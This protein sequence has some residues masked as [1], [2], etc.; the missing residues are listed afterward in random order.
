MPGLLVTKRLRMEGFL[1]S[2]YLEGRADGEAQLADLVASGELTV[3]HE[4]L[5]GLDAAPAAL[6][7]LL[8]GENLGKRM[9]RVGHDPG[10]RS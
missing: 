2:D 9:V 7:G 8:G 3:L 1:L 5:D 4:V 6:V 10:R